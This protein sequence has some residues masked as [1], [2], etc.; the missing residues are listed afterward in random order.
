MTACFTIVTH[1]LFPSK[2]GIL[3]DVLRQPAD[4]ITVSLAHDNRAHE[5][6]D[7]TDALQGDLALASGLVQT[8]FVSES[9]LRNGAGVVDLVAENDKGDLGE[10]LHGQ[11]GVELGLGLGEAVL[12]L[13][14]DQEDDT[15]DLGEVVSPDTTSYWRAWLAF[16]RSRHR[17][18]SICLQHSAIRSRTLVGMIL[19][20][21]VTTEIEGGEADVA[22][23]KL[24]RCC[25][26]PR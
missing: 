17:R 3:L 13:G 6:L 23:G 5:D 10:L 25:A 14:V 15:V 9:V 19:T 11:E 7:G 8:K 24:L 26:A 1:Q 21:G 18:V 4:T 20:L 16:S 12:V 2:T 22:N